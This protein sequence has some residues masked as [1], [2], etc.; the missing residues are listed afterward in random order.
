MKTSLILLLTLFVT[1][2][3]AAEHKYTYSS[4][5]AVDPAVENSKETSAKLKVELEKKC[6]GKWVNDKSSMF[7]VRTMDSDS[8]PVF[9]YDSDECLVIDTYMGGQ[10]PSGT[11]AKNA[12]TAGYKFCVK[13]SEPT[14]NG[15]QQKSKPS[16]R[17]SAS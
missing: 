16:A 11:H 4:F 6:G 8:A 15:P 5:L 13:I 1:T 7:P 10:C 2:A 14:S 9:R 12:D 17:K 3:M